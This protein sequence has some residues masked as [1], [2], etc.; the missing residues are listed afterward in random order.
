MPT[1]VNSVRVKASATDLAA[2]EFFFGS[3][4]RVTIQPASTLPAAVKS[5]MELHGLWPTITGAGIAR[6]NETAEYTPS[7]T[8]AVYP[9]RSLSGIFQ[10]GLTG[11]PV[12]VII[13]QGVRPVY[14]A[15][16][17]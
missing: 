11:S 7:A 4:A 10:F 12:E 13:G 5:A 14:Y 3:W 17:S 15:P 8:T 9:I 6:D 16:L 1:T 2:N